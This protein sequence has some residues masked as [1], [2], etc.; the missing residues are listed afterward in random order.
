MGDIWW[1]AQRGERSAKTMGELGTTTKEKCAAT[2]H[3]LQRAK[4]SV[5]AMHHENR[6]VELIKVPRD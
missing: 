3:A 1:A 2:R 6:F 4:Q 5:E